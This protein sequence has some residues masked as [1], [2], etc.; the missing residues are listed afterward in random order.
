MRGVDVHGEKIHEARTSRAWTQAEL[1]RLAGLDVKTVRK[2]EQGKRIDFI[3]LSRLAE[4]LEIDVV[5]LMARGACESDLEHERRETVFRWIKAYDTRDPEALVSLYKDDAVL[6]IPGGPDVPCSG[7]FRG[8]ELIRQAHEAAWVT[9]QEPARVEELK[10]HADGN[11][12]ALVGEKRFYM[13]NGES[14]ELRAI[15]LFTFD[16]TLF[17]EHEVQ[18]DTLDY[19]QRMSP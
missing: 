13:P 3:P 6:R 4:A 19:V 10:V 15:N 11:T 1:A 5:R 16:G 2:A 12:V 17:I 9:P 8:K 14:F 7:V 18:Y